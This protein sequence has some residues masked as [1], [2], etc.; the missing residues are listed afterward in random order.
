MA[1]R[2]IIMFNRVSADGYFSAPDG[3]LDWAT[4][5]DDI[6][7]EATE[8]LPGADTIILGRKTYDMFEAFWPHA[9]DD[10]GEA[11]DPHHAGRKSPAMRAMAVWINE[12]TKLVF[13]KSK[14][15]VT[16]PNT[17]IIPELDP[18]EVEKLK[19]EPGKAMMIFGS[20]SIVKQL[21]EHGLIDEYH[22]VVSPLILGDGRSLVT[23]LKKSAKLELFETKKYKS[24]TVLLRYR[25]GK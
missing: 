13:S 16:W 7:K 14:K 4:P 18:R 6:D 17:K 21:T 5:D 25:H 10:S 19:K 8:A 22:F 9:L 24:G 20:G 23:G 11:R 12:A 1:N 2:P 3:G 15:E